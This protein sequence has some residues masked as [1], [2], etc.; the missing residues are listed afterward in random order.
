MQ[1]YY[2][3]SRFVVIFVLMGLLLAIYM[4]TL[5]K[6]QLFNSGADANAAYLAD[7]TSKTQTL[8]ANRGEILDRN[9]VPLVSSS[10]VY[11]VTISRPAFQG[12]DDIN[13]VI[14]DLIHTA[15]D[16]DVAYTDTFPVT[17][18]A[19][20][21]YVLDMSDT[22]RKYLNAYLDY[23]HWSP[24]ISASD[25]IVKMKERYGID[26]TM[27]ISDARLVIGVRY[28]LELRAVIYMNS[29][30]FASAI[31]IDFITLLEEK[32]Y[33][34]VNIETSA[35]RVY[36]T[37]YAAHLLGYIGSMSQEEYNNT[38]KARGYSYSA[39]VGKSGA[40]V[41]YE[42]ELHG[43]DGSQTVT[44]ADDGTV[45]NVET[46]TAPIPGKN[47]FLS[48]DIGLQA[49][50]EDSLTAQIDVINAD[51]E[52]ADKDRVTGGAAV[53]T[54][55]NTGEVLALA[56]YPSYDPS[57]LFTDYADLVQNPSQP[58]YNRAIKGTYNPGST[59]KMV[60]GLAGL[61]TGTITPSTVIFDG[62]R[63]M[64]Y[65]TTNPPFIPQCWIYPTTHAG[66]GNE[67]V[68]T[69][70]RDSCNVFFY[71][72]GDE[73]G[74]PALAQAAADFGLGSPTGIELPEALGARPTQEN[75]QRLLKTDDIWYAANTVLSAIGQDINYYTPV[76][77]AKYAATIASGGTKYPLTILN[78]IRSADFTSVVDQPAH[79]PEGTVPG[80]EYIKYLQEGMKLVASEGSASSA[81]KKFFI[82]V[83]A[84]TGTV[85][86]SNTMGNS[87][88][89]NGVLVCYAPAD[90][91]Q[92]AISVVVEKG[93][94]GSTITQIAKDIMSYYFRNKP[95]VTVAQDNTLLP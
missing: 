4:T 11:N 2:K 44:T 69:A 34:G 17:P 54:D 31:D 12:R 39:Q 68:V 74:Q 62:G 9:G 93:T 36:H 49:A 81:F 75:K 52:R 7:G 80:N 40:E 72:V 45:L 8:T 67:T 38:Y 22:Q 63:F 5:Y 66:H 26:Y 57:T 18:G 77:L 28:E 53:V 15:I 79:Q 1:K 43:T 88:L 47:V 21:A 41:V 6:L 10:P 60:T 42:Q 16:N 94:S 58:L 83:A 92:I 25:L 91:P 19:P 82:P 32:R 61:R 64:K 13:T 3:P 14:L 65:A 48:V 55:V 35:K 59:F 33:P 23:C 87:L 89:N 86:S 50:T 56:S 95:D 27:N 73:V 90:N 20:F 76:Q 71:T 29:Y 46:T 24:D 84:K 85:Q 51:P 30:V 37:T 70:L 78:S